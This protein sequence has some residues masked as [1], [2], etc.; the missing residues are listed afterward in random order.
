MLAAFNKVGKIVYASKDLKKAADYICP[1]CKKDVQLKFGVHTRP[2]FA[3]NTK[4]VVNFNNETQEHQNLK[5]V[6]FDW[7]KQDKANSV[8]LEAYLSEIEQR[9]DI[10]VNKLIALE[11]QCSSLSVQRLVE[12]CLA[13]QKIGITVIWLCGKKLHLNGKLSSLN[14]AFMKYTQNAG[15]YYWELDHQKQIIKLLFNVEET[16]DHKIHY[17]VFCLPFYKLPLL[18]ILKLPQKVSPISARCYPKEKIIK[19]YLHEL[20]QKLYFRD[21]KLLSLQE[22]L[23]KHGKNILALPKYFYYPVNRLFACAEDPISWK[24]PF[25]HH[26]KQGLPPSQFHFSKEMKIYQT[27]LISKSIH[28]HQFIYQETQNLIDYKKFNKNI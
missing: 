17:D 11:I 4:C 2:H 8:E 3:H 28:L 27:P 10:L 21:K 12:R 20:Q 14:R 1:I 16:L 18:N 6:M 23:Y 25:Y 13:Y 24:L 26:L 5:E 9:P 7:F 19:H 22:K 15:F